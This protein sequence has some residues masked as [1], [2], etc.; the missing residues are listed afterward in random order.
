M[1][2]PGQAHAW[3]SPDARGIRSRFDQRRT[4]RYRH[5]EHC[6]AVPLTKWPGEWKRLAIAWLRSAGSSIG[7]GSLFKAA[8]NARH[9]AYDVLDALLE[10]GWIELE[11][12]FSRGAW[13]PYR[14]TWTAADDLREVLGVPRRD[15]AEAAR[16]DALG[17]PPYDPRLMALHE[18]LRGKPTRVVLLRAA[19]LVRLDEWLQSERTGTRQQFSHFARGHTK[20]ISQSEWDWLSAHTDLE[21]AG[22]S[23]HTPAIY[24]RAPM[25]L[26]TDSGRID[27]KAVPDLIGLSP[28]TVKAVR[29]IEGS[30]CR[31]LLVENR[32][33]FEDVARRA[34]GSDAV[35]WLPGF[36]PSWWLDAMAH[37]LALFPGDARIAADPDPAGIDIALRAGALWQTKWEPWA[38]SKEAL[39]SLTRTMTLNDYDRERLA[40]HRESPALPSGL[41]ALAK[42][43]SEANKKGEQEGLDLMAW[44]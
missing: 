35:V 42:A 28:G 33:S 22:I 9:L 4:K 36:A 10:S 6:D 15:T 12:R 1:T 37:L 3:G 44:L 19:L 31:W 5:A 32:T 27:L 11:D 30:A 25:V 24:L 41:Q 2:S 16:F 40:I 23:R 13:M 29:A 43:M 20:S 34:G 18:S 26:I 7:Q 8:G 17:K 14:L 21:E 39:E 38:M